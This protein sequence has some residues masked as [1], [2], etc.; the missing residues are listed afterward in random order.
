M[1]YKFVTHVEESHLFL[2]TLVVVLLFFFIFL[3]LS[4]RNQRKKIG[5]NSMKL[6]PGGRGWP[7]IGDSIKWYRAVASSHPPRYVEDQVKRYV[8]I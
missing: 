4:R 7:L 5:S 2:W 6:P 1:S 3:K 8:A